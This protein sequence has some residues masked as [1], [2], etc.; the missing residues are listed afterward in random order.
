M[1]AKATTNIC[2]GTGR[3]KA[4]RTTKTCAPCRPDAPPPQKKKTILP[5]LSG[6]LARKLQA[7]V[8]SIAKQAMAFA[9]ARRPRAMRCPHW[10]CPEGRRSQVS[11]R[12]KVS[13]LASQNHSAGGSW[14]FSLARFSPCA[15]SC[16][17]LIAPFSALP[18]L[19]GMPFKRTY[20]R[21]NSKLKGGSSTHEVNAERNTDLVGFL[22]LSTFMS[23][24]LKL[25]A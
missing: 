6:R 3:P 25:C 17:P 1:V 8:D 13:C 18:L 19:K 22:D 21:R 9:R 12:G 15:S 14:F 5:N 11:L 24:A 20:F 4:G 2:A 10:C 23:L 7:A 16:R